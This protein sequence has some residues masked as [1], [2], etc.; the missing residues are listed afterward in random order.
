MAKVPSP[1]IGVCK[2][3]REGHCIGCAMTRDQKSLF[4]TLK[5]GR[6]KRAFVTMLISQQA[7]MGRYAHW[8]DAYRRRCQKRDADIPF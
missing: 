6:H 8:R 1:C 4:K 2:F 7:V 3:R 5:K